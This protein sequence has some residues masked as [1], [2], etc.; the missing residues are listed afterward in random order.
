M[1]E[2]KF[3]SWNAMRNLWPLALIVLVVDV[4]LTFM[5]YSVS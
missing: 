2:I 5:L 1:R 3:R 4:V